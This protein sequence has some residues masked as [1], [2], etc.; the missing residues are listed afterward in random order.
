MNVDQIYCYM[1]KMKL[2]LRLGP[3]TLSIVTK[4]NAFTLSKKIYFHLLGKNRPSPTRKP[5]GLNAP[6]KKSNLESIPP[7][8][9]HEVQ[10]QNFKGEFIFLAI[11]SY[12]T[13][14]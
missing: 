3:I 5:K 9:L 10:Q 4:I 13:F 2:N 11:Y 12:N 6:N 1:L 7:Y 14:H 8:L